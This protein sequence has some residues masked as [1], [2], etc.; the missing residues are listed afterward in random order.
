MFKNLLRKMVYSFRKP[1][2]G[3]YRYGNSSDKYRHSRKYSSSPS[4]S[5][6]GHSPYGHKYYKNKNRSSS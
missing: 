2:H 1:K 6:Y 4:R 5:G 3:G